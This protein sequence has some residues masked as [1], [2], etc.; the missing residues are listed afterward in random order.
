[1]AILSPGRAASMNRLADLRISP[2]LSAVDPE[3]SSNST[4]SNGDSPDAKNEMSWV[5]PSSSTAKSFCSSAIVFV[6]DLRLKTLTFR[7]TRSVSILT[8]SAGSALWAEAVSSEQWAVSRKNSTARGI[9]YPYFVVE[10]NKALLSLLLT[11]FYSLREI[12]AFAARD[13]AGPID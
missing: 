2:I 13:C 9:W 3:R 7:F 8:T 11:L 6:A 12:S 5:A 1:I 4:R 10:E